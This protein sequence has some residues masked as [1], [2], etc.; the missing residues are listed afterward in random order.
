MPSAA[1]ARTSAM[2]SSRSFLPAG[3]TTVRWKSLPV[4]GWRTVVFLSCG[5]SALEVNRVAAT[6][7]SLTP[8]DFA[9]TRS[10]REGSRCNSALSAMRFCSCVRWRRRTLSEITSAR[11]LRRAI[12]WGDRRVRPRMRAGSSAWPR[13]A[14]PSPRAVLGRHATMRTAPRSTWGARRARRSASRRGRPGR[15]VARQP[16]P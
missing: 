3:G 11:A 6:V 14:R 8:T 10:E 16:G 2:R 4:L 9:M 13:A 7:L 5:I 1:S 15:H 12:H